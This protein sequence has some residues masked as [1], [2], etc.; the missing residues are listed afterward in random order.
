MQKLLIARAARL[1]VVVE[2]LERQ[3]IEDGKIG[4]LAGRQLLAW[5]NTLRHILALLGVQRPAAQTPKLAE[6][7]Q[8]TRAA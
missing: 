4:D 1:T 3:V 6:V 2:S 7:L 5:V 8:V